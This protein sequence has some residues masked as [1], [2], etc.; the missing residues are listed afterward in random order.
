MNVCFILKFKEV[1]VV[2]L[3]TSVE[4]LYK[5]EVIDL[6]ANEQNNNYSFP[7]LIFSQLYLSH[8]TLVLTLA[9][10]GFDLV[11]QELRERSYVEE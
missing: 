8:E 11:F 4:N 5:T 3:S 6:G 7:L 2:T 9:S 10:R 1:Q